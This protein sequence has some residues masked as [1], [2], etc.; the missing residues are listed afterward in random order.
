[1]YVMYSLPI[2]QLSVTGGI[3]TTTARL[4]MTLG[5]AITTAI[6]SHVVP[7]NE[8]IQ[9]NR[10]TAP[11][12]AVFWSAAGKYPVVA[13]VDDRG[14]GRAWGKEEGKVTG[15]FDRGELEQLHRRRRWW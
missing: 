7:G 8:S 10:S 3:S 14:A 13:V 1:M 11:Y 6:F 9:A 5:L 15:G 12:R 2:S 4:C